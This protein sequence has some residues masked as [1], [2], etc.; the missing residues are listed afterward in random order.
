MR[1]NSVGTGKQGERHVMCRAWLVQSLA[2][3]DARKDVYEFKNLPVV[4]F[5]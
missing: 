4:P 5:N 2:C 3:A 1:G